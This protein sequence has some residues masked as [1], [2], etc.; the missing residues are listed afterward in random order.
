MASTSVTTMSTDLFVPEVL[1]DYIEQ[2]YIDYV[3]FAPL[4]QVDNTLEGRPG[5]TLTMPFWKVNSVIPATADVLEGHDIP[6]AKLEQDTTTA[7]VG[8]FGVGV[9]FTDEAEMNGWGNTAEE[10]VKQI[11]AGIADKL[12]AKMLTEMGNASLTATVTKASGDVGGQFGDALIKFG[13]DIDGEKVLLVDP[14]TYGLLRHS[15]DWIP[16]TE[17]GAE[18]IIKGAVGMIHG[19]QIV[20]TNRL[21]G[22]NLAYIVKPGALRIVSKRGV[23]VETDRDIIDQT[24]YITGTKI[25]APYLYNDSKIIKITI[26]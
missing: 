3:R 23:L 17:I 7:T 10:A 21:T 19:C 12:E 4:A 15:K 24:N 22:Q 1:A 2:K 6:I 16:N 11:L 14:A 26:A 25:C 5:D 18:L 20:V 13:E 8:K 9:Q